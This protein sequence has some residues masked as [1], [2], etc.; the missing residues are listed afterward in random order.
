MNKALIYIHG[1]GGNIEEA[2]HYRPLFK[3][4]DV[5]GFDYK[6]CNPWDS[7]IEFK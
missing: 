7:R 5:I 2:D 3:D 4:Y 1:S 6:S